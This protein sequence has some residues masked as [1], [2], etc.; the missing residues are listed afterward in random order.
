MT[1]EKCAACGS[2]GIVNRRPDVALEFQSVEC[3]ECE[4]RT[5]IQHGAPVA[6]SAVVINRIRRAHQSV[7]NC[8]DEWRN[9]T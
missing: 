9:E 3:V 8:F 1:I 4:A 5:E 6:I 7:P 2:T